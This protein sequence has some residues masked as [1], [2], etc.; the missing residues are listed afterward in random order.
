MELP[1]LQQGFSP[2]VPGIPLVP[3]VPIV[4]PSTL[5]PS[6][7]SSTSLPV[8]HTGLTT[9]TSMLPSSSHVIQ[10]APELKSIDVYSTDPSLLYKPVEDLMGGQ[11][12]TTAFIGSLAEGVSDDL[13]QRI[14]EVF[15]DSLIDLALWKSYEMETAIRSFWKIQK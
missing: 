15:M 8:Y 2:T 5:L 12:S 10:A 11:V 9:T 3:P 4:N 1:M 14:L 6:V 13:I 7:A